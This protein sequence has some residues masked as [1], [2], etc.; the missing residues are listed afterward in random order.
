MESKCEG[1]EMRK[2]IGFAL[3]IVKNVSRLAEHDNT[4]MMGYHPER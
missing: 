3:D 1:E 4:L 2:E